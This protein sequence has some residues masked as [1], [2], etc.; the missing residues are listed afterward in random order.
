MVIIST[1]INVSQSTL[2]KYFIVPNSSF[3]GHGSGYCNVNSLQD[4]LF[5]YARDNKFA[6]LNVAIFEEMTFDYGI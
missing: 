3:I 4:A 2:C 6:A 1:Q 5:H